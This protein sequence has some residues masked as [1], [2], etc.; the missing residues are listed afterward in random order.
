ML[1]LICHYYVNGTLFVSLFLHYIINTSSGNETSHCCII[2]VLWYSG[3]MFICLCV[4]NDG[5]LCTSMFLCGSMQ[6]PCVYVGTCS[7]LCLLSHW[8]LHTQLTP[9]FTQCH[10]AL[11]CIVPH[12]TAL[13]HTQHTTMELTLCAL[14]LCSGVLWMCWTLCTVNALYTACCANVF[15]NVLHSKCPVHCMMC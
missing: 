8:A 4:L 14:Y 9:Q 15:L 11:H 10:W 1:W 3:W 12:F 7:P 13:Y 2:P 5:L 6:L